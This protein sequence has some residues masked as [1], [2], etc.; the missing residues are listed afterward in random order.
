MLARERWLLLLLLFLAKYERSLAV[1]LATTWGRQLQ[2][3][4]DED[5]LQVVM[6]GGPSYLIVEEWRAQWAEVEATVLLPV[7]VVALRTGGVPLR[8]IPAARGYTPSPY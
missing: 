8:A 6:Q 7:Y 1:R 4:T 2:E 3:P 5:L